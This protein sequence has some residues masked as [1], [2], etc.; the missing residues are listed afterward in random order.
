MK[1]PKGMQFVLR[2]WVLYVFVGSYCAKFAFEHI[3]QHKKHKI[4]HK[5]NIPN[6]CSENYKKPQ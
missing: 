6:S 1:R 5:T 4:A 3:L 2:S